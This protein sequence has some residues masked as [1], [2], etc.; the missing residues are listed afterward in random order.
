MLPYRHLLLPLVLAGFA[1]P[2]PAQNVPEFSKLEEQRLGYER[3]VMEARAAQW[4]AESMAARERIQQRFFDLQMQR[5]A[6]ANAQRKVE[7]EE[8]ARLEKAVLA[9]QWALTHFGRE[10][11][12]YL[13][14]PQARSSMV[15][16]WR[17]SKEVF[18][19]KF[20][21]F[22]D[23]SLA[24]IK[25]GRALNFFLDACGQLAVEHT[26]LLAQWENEK[27]QIA[28]AN[29]LDPALAELNDR[30]NVLKEFE[31]PQEF[32][33]DDMYSVQAVRGLVGEKLRIRLNDEPLPLEWPEAIRNDARYKPYTAQVELLRKEILRQLREAKGPART[34]EAV[35]PELQKQLMAAA[36]Q[37]DLVYTGDTERLYRSLRDPTYMGPAIALDDRRKRMVAARYLKGMLEGVTRFVEARKLSDLEMV[38]FPPDD[39]PVKIREVFDFMSRQGLRFAE[40]DIN[41]E[42]TYK[43]LYDAMRD[44]YMDLYQMQFAMIAEQKKIDLK[45]ERIREL[46]NIEMEKFATV[47]MDTINISIMGGGGTLQDQIGGVL[48]ELGKGIV[49]E[50]TPE[51]K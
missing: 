5:K 26:L 2:C 6:A 24:E 20:L 18:K 32:T 51:L 28:M 13:P 47:S 27:K 7:E 30:I 43:R 45:N 44:Y 9:K 33:R 14:T 8:V 29:S 38:Q 40:G 46:L 31:G 49:D 37:L 48:K 23:Q 3:A 42:A 35:S 11:A 36:N 15:E 34:G 10:D 16:Q 41:D 12:A 25:S 21:R 19:D 50:G 17:R 1:A 22:P 39:R 4:N